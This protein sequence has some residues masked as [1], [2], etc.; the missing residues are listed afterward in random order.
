MAKLALNLISG[1]KLLQL[2]GRNLGGEFL[3]RFR[4]E[5]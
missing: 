5:G 2:F 4:S 1:K 3:E